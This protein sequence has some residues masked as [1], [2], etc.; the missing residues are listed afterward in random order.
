M[1][2]ILLIS[3]GFFAEKLIESSQMLVGK[4]ENLEAIALE[5][6]DNFERFQ[7]KIAKRV[8]QLDEGD[9]V[10]V[11]VDLLGGSPYNAVAKCFKQNS[12]IECL[13]GM[14]MSM[15]LT[16]LDQRTY[17]DLEQLTEECRIAASTNIVNVRQALL[18]P[19]DDE[20]E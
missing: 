16:A 5:P 8:R 3:H 1:I 6:G 4:S 7:Q 10:L 18:A 9:G 2:P 17:Y 12:H 14:N 15:L 13:T 19:V 20:D 11:L